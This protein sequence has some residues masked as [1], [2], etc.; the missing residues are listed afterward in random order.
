[1]VYF[2]KILLLFLAGVLCFCL[3]ACSP[4]DGEA[5]EI[6]G[7]DLAEKTDEEVIS[8]LLAKYEAYN[9]S[10]FEFSYTM[11]GIISDPEME[12]VFCQGVSLQAADGSMSFVRTGEDGTVMESC[13]YV[14]GILY[15]Y[16]GTEKVQYSLSRQGAVDQFS[17]QYT[18]YFEDL[19]DYTA[20]V[21]LRS[22]D[23]SYRIVLSAPN[24]AAMLRWKEQEFY[25]EETDDTP[26]ESVTDYREI[27]LS[28]RFSSEGVPTGAALGFDYTWTYDGVDLQV[29]NTQTWQVVSTD[30]ATI[31]VSAP[32]DADDYEEGS[33]P[34]DTDSHTD[35]HGSSASDDSDETTDE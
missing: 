32:E 13:I 17:S 19:K 25:V 3:A 12:D 5:L 23:G 14:D 34:E 18:F 10:A 26:A 24:E 33:V 4:T 22:E 27:Y 31:S 30:G 2:K 7:K 20:R 15:L 16:D 9:P 21:L 11:H 8:I 35:S 1:M 28:L 29:R 6:T